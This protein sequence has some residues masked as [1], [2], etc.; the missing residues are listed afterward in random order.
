ERQ[1]QGRDDRQQVVVRPR[2]RDREEQDRHRNPETEIRPEIGALSARAPAE[3]FAE[4]RGHEER[5][6]KDEERHGESRG[7]HRILV[8]VGRAP[9][10]QEPE[11]VLVDE[12]EPGEARVPG[13]G[14]RVPRHRDREKEEDSGRAPRVAEPTEVA[15]EDRVRENHQARKQDAEEALG[16]DREARRGVGGEKPFPARSRRLL[17][18]GPDPEADQGERGPESEE[19]V[20]GHLAREEQRAYA[21]RESRRGNPAGGR[22]QHPAG[23][24]EG[25]GGRRE[26]RKGRG[27]AG[28]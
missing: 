16:Q 13:R 2:A 3:R 12:V 17:R 15:R 26:A 4:G 21:R 7:V 22:T 1:G 23:R 19:G 10:P 28:A 18:R 9:P 20:E 5:P 8:K 11:P 27:Y 25:G 24:D 14:G 6:G